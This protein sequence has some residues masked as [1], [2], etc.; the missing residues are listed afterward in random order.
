VSLKE[1][2]AGLLN[3]CASKKSEL[4][5][6]SPDCHPD[7]LGQSLGFGRGRILWPVDGWSI[8]A[9]SRYRCLGRKRFNI[10]LFCP[11]GCQR[12]GLGCW[13]AVITGRTW[14]R[15]VAAVAV[16]DLP[17][18]PQA[19]LCRVARPAQGDRAPCAATRPPSWPDQ[20]VALTA[21]RW[22]SGKGA[23]AQLAAWAP[24]RV[25]PAAVAAEAPL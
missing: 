15:R 12:S 6:M 25:R 4:F 17:A 16:C 23:A 21:C 14:S 2:R 19:V 10:Q 22:A 11:V 9:W 13:P 18:G 7:R 20:Y 8:N 5:R 24:L 3:T 1:D